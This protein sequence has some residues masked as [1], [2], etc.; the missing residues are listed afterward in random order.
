MHYVPCNLCG[1][2]DTRPRFPSTINGHAQPSAPTAFRCTHPGYGRHHAIVECARCG[3][4]YTNPRHDGRD[5]LEAYVAVE[6]PLYVQERDG[7]V[8]T[9]ERHLRPLMQLKPPPGRLLDV[10]AYIGVFVEIARRHGWDAWGVEPSSWAV[11]EARRRGLQ[12]IEGTLES[13][14][15][16]EPSYDVI[17]MWDVIEHVTDPLAEISRAFQLLKP[18]GLLVLHT[19][20][21]DSAFARLMGGRWPWLMEMHIYYFSRRTLSAMLEKAGFEVLRAIPQ[22]RFLRLGYFATRLGGLL[23]ERVGGTV[24]AVV[25]GLGAGELAIPVNVGDLMTAYAVK[26]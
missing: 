24:G 13:M 16:S 7:R 3:L 15:L 21:I 10:G 5:I 4:V 17:T 23:G 22:G 2:T 25:G 14:D 8:L 11:G 19:M 1:S 20:D 9:F 18:G 12:M 26:R 6:D